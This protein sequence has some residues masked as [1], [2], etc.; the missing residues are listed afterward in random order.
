MV[1]TIFR[2]GAVGGSSQLWETS[3]KVRG[4]A[5]PLREDEGRN[6]KQGEKG[7]V[8]VGILERRICCGALVIWRYGRNAIG[9]AVRFMIVMSGAC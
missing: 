1:E 3:L 5:V 8:E 9:I 2:L 6:L 4:H 7:Q